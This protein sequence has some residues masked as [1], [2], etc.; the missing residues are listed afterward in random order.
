MSEYEVLECPQ[1]YGT[2]EVP[3]P[4]CDGN[5]QVFVVP[6]WEDCE[7]CAGNGCSYGYVKCSACDGRGYF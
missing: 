6:G 5:G 4:Q 2:G 3:C 1:C 7:V